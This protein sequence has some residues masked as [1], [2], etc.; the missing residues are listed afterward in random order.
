MNERR[1]LLKYFLVL[2]LVLVLFITS[3]GFTK[4]RPKKHTSAVY[5]VTITNLTSQGQAF[6]PPL[7]GK[8]IDKENIKDGIYEGH[9]K[10]GPVKVVAKVNIEKQRI[11]KIELLSH[12]TWKGK[13]AE[14][15]IPNWII[16]E[17]S[18]KV[19]AVSGATISSRVIMNAVQNAIDNANREWKD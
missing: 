8:K 14:K 10:S 6:T 12:R 11:A 13:K 1:H 19:D 16:E 3:T 7:I 5:E 9:Y 2:T 17:Q 15:I 4:P 18:T